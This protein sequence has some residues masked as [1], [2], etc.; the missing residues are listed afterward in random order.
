MGAFPQ[1]D[2]DGIAWR[3]TMQGE[4]SGGVQVLVGM[5]ANSNL[6]EADLEEEVREFA[7]SLA[8]RLGVSITSIVRHESTSSELDLDTPEEP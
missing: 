1:L 5:S 6:D 4:V 3:L 8:D 7:D 2:P